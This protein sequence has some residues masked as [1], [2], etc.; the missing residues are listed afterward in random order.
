[1]V[2]SGGRKQIARQI[3]LVIDRFTQRIINNSARFRPLNIRFYSHLTPNVLIFSENRY[4]ISSSS[5]ILLSNVQRGGGEGAWNRFVYSRNS[6]FYRKTVSDKIRMI[7]LNENQIPFQSR[8]NVE[9]NS[10]KRFEIE[11][12]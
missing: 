12:R 5:P 8:R 4:F 10:T 9:T 1:M 6:F 3:I 7:F 11:S 2:N